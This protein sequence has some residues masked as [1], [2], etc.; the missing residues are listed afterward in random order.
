MSLIERLLVPGSTERPDC[1]CGA[2][3]ALDKVE[4]VA[5]NDDVQIRVYRCPSCRHELRLTVWF[6]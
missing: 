6:D 2:E 3:M 5:K 4:A 1:K